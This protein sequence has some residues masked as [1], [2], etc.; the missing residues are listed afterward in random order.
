MKLIQILLLICTVSLTSCGIN[1][2]DAYVH[3]QQ[4]L[5]QQC[6]IEPL[7]LSSGMF[8]V[9]N[10]QT[11]VFALVENIDNPRYYK[12]WRVLQNTPQDPQYIE[13]NE[14]EQFFENAS[15]TTAEKAR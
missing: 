3:L 12:V 2:F 11:G 7:P 14:I 13:R 6:T 9:T 15:L 10:P 1:E 8:F 4:S 5:S